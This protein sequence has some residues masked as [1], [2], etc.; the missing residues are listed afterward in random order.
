MPASATTARPGC[1]KRGAQVAHP[2]A[3]RVPPYAACTVASFTACTATLFSTQGFSQGAHEHR[4][5]KGEQQA[6]A[7]V[8]SGSVPGWQSGRD[9]L[10]RQHV[11]GRATE[12]QGQQQRQQQPQQPVFTSTSSMRELSSQLHSLLPSPPLLLTLGQAPVVQGVALE[13][14]AQL[15]AGVTAA[16][17]LCQQRDSGSGAGCSTLPSGAA[18]VPSNHRA[19][20]MHPNGATQH[21]TPGRHA[22][23]HTPWAWPRAQCRGQRV[24]ALPPPSPQKR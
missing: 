20:P 18:S 8:C 15:R 13:Q 23:L 17:V 3:C 14:H 19:T 5:A 1:G 21:C 16:V 11:S 7:V 12:V 4:E 6:H 22:A 10:R 24:R 9:M 2:I